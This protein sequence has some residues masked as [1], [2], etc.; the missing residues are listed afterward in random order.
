MVKWQVIN[1]SSAGSAASQRAIGTDQVLSQK[2]LD[3]VEALKKF[4]AA[5]QQRDPGAELSQYIFSIA[6]ILRRV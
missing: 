3:S 2:H 5:H 6:G 4:V 1:K